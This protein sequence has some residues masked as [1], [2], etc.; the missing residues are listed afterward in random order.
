MTLPIGAPHYAQSVLGADLRPGDRIFPS[1]Y[2][3]PY[4]L[5]RRITATRWQAQRHS[6]PQPVEALVTINP[7]A[8]YAVTSRPPVA[9]LRWVEVCLSDLAAGDV[10]PLG[11]VEWIGKLHETFNP[12]YRLRSAVR[13]GLLRRPNGALVPHTWTDGSIIRQRVTGGPKL[14][15]AQAN[16]A[17][18]QR[19]PGGSYV[20]VGGVATQNGGGR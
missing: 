5:V 16:P 17:L 15:A 18:V 13:K 10:L 20:W 11:E 7:A 1:R 2:A 6:F 12:I 19:S 14:A 4:T 8:Q 9:T 3:T